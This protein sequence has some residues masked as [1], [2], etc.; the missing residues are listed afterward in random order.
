MHEPRPKSGPSLTGKL[1]R[2]K[3]MSAVALTNREMGLVAALYAV[4]MLSLYTLM[5]SL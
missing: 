2:M 5:G 1:D 3:P 4:V